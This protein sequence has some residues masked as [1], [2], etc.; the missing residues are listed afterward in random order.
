[1]KF[2]AGIH[3]P[4]SIKTADYDDWVYLLAL[5]SGVLEE[6]SQLI[7]LDVLKFFRLAKLMMN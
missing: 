5:A 7:F 3:I 1:M 2:Y 4:C 6:T